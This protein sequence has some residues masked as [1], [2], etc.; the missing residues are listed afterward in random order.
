MLIRTPPACVLNDFA[1]GDLEMKTMHIEGILYLTRSCLLT[2]RPPQTV[3]S[4]T[5]WFI[6]HSFDKK[7][8]SL[9]QRDVSLSHSLG[10]VHLP[11]KIS[12]IS[13]T[14]TE[15]ICRVSLSQETQRAQCIFCSLVRLFVDS[16]SVMK[17][18]CKHFLICS[19]RAVKA[20]SH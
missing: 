12:I 5:S 3:R 19:W 1:A 2:P 11:D 18:L 8:K 14:W 16:H 9:L 7:C 13:T 6:A 15:N 4:S 17:S 10:L 20:A